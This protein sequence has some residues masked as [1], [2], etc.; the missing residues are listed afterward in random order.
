MRELHLVSPHT[1]G[2]TVKALQY[3]LN[4]HNAF[5]LNFHAGNLDGEYGPTTAGA[6]K[7]AKFALGYTTKGV[8]MVAGD[9]FLEI[10]SG[11]KKLSL[12]MKVRKAVRAKAA[13]KIAAQRGSLV[14]IAAREL[15]NHE[16]PANSNSGPRV[17]VYQSVTGAYH[18]AWCASFVSWCLLTQLGKSARKFFPPNPAY[19]PS[20]V[21]TARAHRNGLR[22][23]SAAEA[24]P[25]DIV[26]YDWDGGVADHIGILTSTVSGGVF[27]TIE[28]NTAFGNDSN[29]GAVMRRTRYT[30][31]VEAFIR[32]G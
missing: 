24:R 12:A 23:I 2:E 16:I 9:L 1:R 10:L 27:H 22:V 11:R 19:C 8:N 32:I 20:W 30:N 6:V 31:Q 7:R 17:R 13:A 26:T 29:G 25:G 3:L 28:G 18:A 5:K 21:E 15:G 14:N 4:G